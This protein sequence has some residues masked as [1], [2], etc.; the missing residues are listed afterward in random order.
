VGTAH[1][2][3]ASVDEVREVIAREQPTVVAVEL[4]QARFTALTE[5]EAW[6]QTKLTDLIK[7]GRAFLLLAQAFLGS[8]QRRLG[9][10]FGVQPGAEMLAAIEES[11]SRNIELALADRDIGITLKRAWGRM[12]VRE[13]MRISWEFMKALT[14][15]AEAED[16]EKEM[17]PEDLL[18]EDA[19]TL[20]MEEL[21]Q[22]APSVSD[23]LVK[24]RDAYLAGRIRE[25]A[26]KAGDGKVVAVIGAGHLRGVESYLKEPS[27]IPEA[28]TLET[29]PEKFPWGKVVAYGLFAFFLG[30]FAVLAYEVFVGGR[31]QCLASLQGLALQW[32]LLKGGLAGLGA[33]LA[34]GHP[35]TILV[36]FVM[37]PL[38]PFHPQLSS[39]ILAGLTEAKFRPPRVEDYEGISKLTRLRDFWRNR[40]TRVL[41]V[42]ALVN[43]GSTI[44]TIVLASTFVSAL[45]CL[46]TG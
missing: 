10:R 34:L 3:Q 4:D 38:S 29:L 37:A 25:A 17:K 41:L 16:A 39:G 36:A 45:G 11:K 42:A 21:S 19:L 20:M 32:V 24:E 31:I 22:V 30:V 15:A 8:Y 23:V 7:Q 33:I 26:Q 14:G 28:A 46:A 40:F 12:G 13:K 1:I 9:E 5:P 2:S 43:V 27:R 44:A 6:K 35:L 18:Q